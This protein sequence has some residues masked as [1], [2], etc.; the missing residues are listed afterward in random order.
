MTKERSQ[1]DELVTW[2]QIPAQ[3]SGATQRGK[4]EDHL[5]EE[6]QIVTA[7]RATFYLHGE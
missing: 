4:L 6:G 2:K 7:G 3:H 1:E 5:D